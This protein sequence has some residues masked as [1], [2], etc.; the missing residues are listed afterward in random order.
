MEEITIEDFIDS[1][2]EERTMVGKKALAVKAKNLV[3]D[4]RASGDFYSSMNSR[5]E[6]EKRELESKNRQLISIAYAMSHKI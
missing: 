6:H 4:L 2:V 1:M 3:V 5:L